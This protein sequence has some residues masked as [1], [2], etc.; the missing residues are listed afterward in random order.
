MVSSEKL[1]LMLS[2]H[3]N[4]ELAEA[5]GPQCHLL[6]LGLKQSLVWGLEGCGHQGRVSFILF[7]CR[8]DPCC[9]N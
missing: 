4:S 9:G 8:G 6:V 1:N 3:E 7:I 5:R 2:E